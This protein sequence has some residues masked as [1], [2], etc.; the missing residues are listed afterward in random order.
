MVGNLGS[1]AKT[2]CFARKASPLR[3]CTSI[4]SQL[5]NSLTLYGNGFKLIP[6]RMGQEYDFS[7]FEFKIGVLALYFHG[8]EP[9]RSSVT[10]LLID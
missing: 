10:E 3:T 1:H 7:P 4:A 9:G 8:R 6:D 5:R 2:R